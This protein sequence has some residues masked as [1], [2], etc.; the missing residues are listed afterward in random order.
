MVFLVL[1]RHG[2]SMWNPDPKRPQ[3][4]WKYAG[5]LDVPLNE[6][7]ILEALKAGARLRH[8][9]LDVV[10]SSTLIRAQTTALITLASH[11]SGKTP[12]LIR[13]CNRNAELEFESAI[14]K[15]AVAD[16]I[17]VYCSNNLNERDFGLLQGM[18][19]SEQNRVFGKERMQR[20]RNDFYTP[21][22][23]GESSYSVM[24]RSV[25]FF[26][27]HVLPY[28]ME[29]KNALICCHGFV[30]RTLI[31][32]LSGMSANDWNEHMRLEKVKDAH[33][34]LRVPNATPVVYWYSE[35]HFT[36][37]RDWKMI[38]EPSTIEALH[39]TKPTSNEN[40]SEAQKDKGQ[41]ESIFGGFV[42]STV[43]GVDL[44]NEYSS[45]KCF[46]DSLIELHTCPILSKL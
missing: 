42:S 34:D 2:Q 5:A 1:L 38:V 6:S 15:D 44:T 13:N 9:P 46:N 11:S 10:F 19:H 21:A 27:E 45:N 32:H 37:V 24:R 35:G 17:P 33:S 30:L 25:S 28:L 16:I 26:T 36:R 31:M 14:H 20:I 8:I 4:P 23:E 43:S 41:D 40:E 29:N 7:G 22:P 18:H 12:M 3:K 39:S